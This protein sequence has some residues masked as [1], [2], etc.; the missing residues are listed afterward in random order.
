MIIGHLLDFG[1]VTETTLKNHRE[2]RTGDSL[3]PLV[4]QKTD[5]SQVLKRP[6]TNT[7]GS[8][9]IFTLFSWFF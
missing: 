5:P 3:S 8:L 7:F 1:M 4:T 2:T 6:L 9:K